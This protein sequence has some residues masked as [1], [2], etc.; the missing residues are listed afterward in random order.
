M[1]SRTIVWKERQ[2]DAEGLRQP[3]V[4]HGRCRRRI[5]SQRPQ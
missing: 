5:G 1:K 3:G 4:T 2:H